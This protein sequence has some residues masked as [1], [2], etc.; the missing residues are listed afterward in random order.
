MKPNLYLITIA[1]RW[2]L[3]YDNVE[4]KE[5]LRAHWPSSTHGQAI[6]TARN[7]SVGFDLVD[8][9]L[10]IM[11]WDED[12]A[13]RYFFHLLARDIGA[14]VEQTD[15]ASAI[16]L[17]RKLDGHALAISVAAAMIHQRRWTV[18][19]FMKVYDE[20]PSEMLEVSGSRSINALWKLSFQTLS[21]NGRII[22][23][24]LS[25][26][27]SDSIPQ[28]LFDIQPKDKGKLDNRLKFC[29]DSFE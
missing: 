22:L 10:E 26:M 29:E 25:Y 27:A 20:H 19:D 6:V 16:Q 21:S 5:L 13:T 2:F 18:S 9:T 7:H 24:I 11:K 15:R 28:A 23:G 12:T 8:G 14:D 17:S 3:I 4:S 1:C